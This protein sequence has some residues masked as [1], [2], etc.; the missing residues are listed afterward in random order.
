MKQTLFFWAP[1]L[2][3]EKE[4]RQACWKEMKGIGEDCI[5]SVRLF[6][7]NGAG[8]R[9]DWFLETFK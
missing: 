3:G 9:L 6:L 5:E 2:L 4:G 1:L 8:G 7:K